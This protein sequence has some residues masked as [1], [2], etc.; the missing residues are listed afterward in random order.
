V[1]YDAIP[2]RMDGSPDDVRASLFSEVEHS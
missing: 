2:R 1:Y